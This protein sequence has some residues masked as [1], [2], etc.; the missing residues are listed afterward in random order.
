MDIDEVMRLLDERIE[1]LTK[2]AVL[3]GN[4]PKHA[5][6]ILALYEFKQSI[7]PKNQ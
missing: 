2:R 6:G 1:L 4:N 3:D 5:A 7:T